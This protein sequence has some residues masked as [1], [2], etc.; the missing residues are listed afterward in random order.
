[1]SEQSVQVEATVSA[2]AFTLEQ[3]LRIQAMINKALETQLKQMAQGQVALHFQDAL[4]TA[5][6]ETQDLPS[7]TT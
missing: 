3:E 6:R 5:L 7:R 2:T 1:M 4:K